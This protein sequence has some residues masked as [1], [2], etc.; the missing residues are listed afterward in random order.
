[1]TS[2]LVEQYLART[3]RGM[4]ALATPATDADLDDLAV[5]VVG[6]LA[7]MQATPVA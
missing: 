7:A 2:S 3:P 5:A 1:V 4:G 6:R